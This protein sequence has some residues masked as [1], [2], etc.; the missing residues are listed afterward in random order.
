MTATRVFYNGREDSKQP[1]FVVKGRE[2]YFMDSYG[3]MVPFCNDA[4]E[5]IPFL[6]RRELE[7]N[8]ADLSTVMQKSLERL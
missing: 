5:Y 4:N 1:F 7:L 6:E 8:V 3:S 2:G